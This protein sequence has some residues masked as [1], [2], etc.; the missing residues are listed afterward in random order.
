MPAPGSGA[1]NAGYAVVYDNHGDMQRMQMANLMQQQN[2][3]RQDKIAE[4]QKADDAHRFALQKYYGKDFDPNNFDIKNDLQGRVNDYLISGKKSLSDVLNKP[5]VSDQDIDNAAQQ[6]LIPAQKLYQVGTAINRN[7]DTSLEGLKGEKGIDLGSLKKQAYIN[8]L[9]TKDPQ[10]GKMRIKN[11]QELSQIDPE[12]NYAADILQNHPELVAK[13]DVDYNG[14]LKLFQPATQKLTGEWYSSPGVKHK[15]AFEATWADGPQKLVQDD[16]GAYKVETA[17]EPIETTDANG[18]KVLINQIPQG[19]INTMQST[20]G[21]KAKLDVATMQY[22]A[23]THPDVSVEPNTPAFEI[24]KRAMVYDMFNKTAP[25]RISQGQGVNTSSPVIRMQ[26]GLDGKKDNGSQ[27]Q[28]MQASFSDVT[29]TP[30][31]GDNGVKGTINNGKF[32]PDNGGVFSK[33]LPKYKGGEVS[34][35]IPI[36]KLPISVRDAVVKYS[37]GNDVTGEKTGRRDT[38]TGM[39]KVKINDGVVSAVMTDKGQWFDVNSR[40]NSNIKAQNSTVPMKEKQHYKLHT[41]SKVK[42]DPLGLF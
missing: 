32:E 8:A 29:D 17:N 13:G 22:L 40:L 15:S 33:L 39:V 34:G 14:A 31:I 5:G 4:Q 11:D 19:V 3:A 10:T 35:L 28:D 26:L 1:L 16:K 21:A 9:Y 37:Q 7:I 24:A 25:K 12:H 30:F 6:A 18:R 27:E 36:T 42:K 38:P 20:P 41:E 2:Q 23:K